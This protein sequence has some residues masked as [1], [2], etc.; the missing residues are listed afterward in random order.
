MLSVKYETRYDI[1]AYVS[2]L[3]AIVALVGLILIKS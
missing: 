1:I 2:I 3:L